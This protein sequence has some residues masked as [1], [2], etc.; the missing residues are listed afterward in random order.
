MGTYK[1]DGTLIPGTMYNATDYLIGA[2]NADNTTFLQI[3]ID[4][5]NANGGGIIWFPVGTY[6]FGG[7]ILAKSNVSIVG[8][9]IEKTIFKKTT[10][11]AY[12]L[13]SYNTGDKDTPITGCTY[14][15]FT[16]D[17]YDTGN[18]N[19][20]RGKSFFYQYVKNC[21][22]RDIIL[23]GSIATALGVDFLDNV[24]IDHVYCV[25]CGRTYTGSEQGTSGIGIGTGGWENENFLI[26]NCVCVGSGQYGI[27]IENQH[28]VF[29]NAGHVDY[30]KGCIISNCVVRNGLNHGIGI[31][32][33][34]NVTVIGCES[35]ENAVDGFIIKQLCKN[36]KITGCSAAENGANG[37]NMT[38]NAASD[39]VAIRNNTCIDNAGNGINV[40]ASTSGLCISENYT[41]GNAAGLVFTAVT[42]TDAVAKNNYA[43]DGVT[44]SATFN[45]NTSYIDTL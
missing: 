3:L 2:N 10:V 36:V 16:V 17:E 9:N 37:I 42:L 11:G 13:F 41:N 8:E 25:D 20:V 15:N 33:G 43:I 31:V 5:V 14:A 19:S 1:Y 45:G 23:K 34:Q 28:T 38:Q 12:P 30:S 6:N 4:Q 39:H 21:V 44:S 32:G 35:Y 29:G 40:Q 27:F 18:T 26:T 24:V 22:F 7:T